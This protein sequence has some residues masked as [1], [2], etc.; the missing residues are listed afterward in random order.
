[1][2]TIKSFIVLILV[3]LLHNCTSSSE[4]VDVL[5][6]EILRNEISDIKLKAQIEVDVLLMDSLITKEKIVDLLDFLYEKNS[7]RKGFK[8]HRHP[9]NIYIYVFS[10]KEKAE[11]GAG[12]WVGM[13][14]KG[15]YDNEPIIRINDIQLRSLNIIPIVKFGLSEERREEIWKNLIHT[16][17]KAEKE[18]DLKFPVDLY[19]DNFDAHDAFFRKQRLKYKNQLA[20]DYGVSVA[21]I[22]SIILEARAKGW[23]F[24]KR[25]D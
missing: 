10:T 12:Q 3:L 5:Q 14:S 23:A 20:K 9:T 2:K 18:A 6:H 19:T 15:F 22:D 8:Y 13:I 7:K 11:A 1:M 21:I 16:E 25:I 17:D 24:P 4:K